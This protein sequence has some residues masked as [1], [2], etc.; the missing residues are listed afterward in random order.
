MFALLLLFLPQF[1]VHELADK[2]SVRF[3]LKQLARWNSA[4]FLFFLNLMLS[5]QISELLYILF[6]RSFLCLAVWSYLMLDFCSDV[7]YFSFGLIQV[8]L[9]CIPPNINSVN[10]NSWWDSPIVNGIKWMTFQ[11]S[12]LW[13]SSVHIPRQHLLS[14]L[15]LDLLIR[16]RNM[17]G[18]LYAPDMLRKIPDFIYPIF[19]IRHYVPLS[20]PTSPLCSPFCAFESRSSCLMWTTT[21]CANIYL[22]ESTFW[23]TKLSCWS[24]PSPLPGEECSIPDNP[25]KSAHGK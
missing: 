7:I 11:H 24:A 5:T 25:S 21:R 13:S 17:F 12:T 3:V 2:Y 4:L 15:H 23:I 8:S 18:F 19:S 22:E 10:I 16:K 20:M 1:S 6:L 9:F 14:S